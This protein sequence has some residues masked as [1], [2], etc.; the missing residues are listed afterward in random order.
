MSIRLQVLLDETEYRD[1]QRAARQRRVTVSAW[2]RQMIREL[3]NAE[4]LG[5]PERKLRVVRE[6]ARHRYPAPPVETLLAEIEQG[7]LSGGGDA[8]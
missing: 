7:Y 3:I 1:L 4:P 5:D 2:V 6:A 8:P